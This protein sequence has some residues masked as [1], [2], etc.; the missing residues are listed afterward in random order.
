MY[1]AAATSATL[2][3]GLAK[4]DRDLAIRT[5]EIGCPYCG[6]ALDSSGWE[7]KP[8]G[9]GQVPEGVCRRHGLCCRECRQRTLP[10]SAVFLGR[11]V[12]FGA[13]VLVSIASRQR[14]L[15]GSTASA[16]R[17]LFGVSKDTLARWLSFFMVDF[18]VSLAW[19]SVRGRISAAVR[20]EELP[21][22]LLAEFD[23]AVGPGEPA[24][25]ACLTFLAGGQ[26]Q[27][28]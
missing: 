25:N 5:R 9:L 2:C 27:A 8:R 7:R 11:K 10:R 19:M 4:I 26:L 20:S 21:S 22:A 15:V 16:L 17:R 14:Q 1:P 6:G 3:E 23:R 24:L 28:S 18:P 12:Y 13:V